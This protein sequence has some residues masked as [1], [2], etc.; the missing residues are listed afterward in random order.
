MKK[1]SRIQKAAL[2]SAALCLCST[3]AW[4]GNSARND[5]SV[6]SLNYA[7]ES[8]RTLIEIGVQSDPTFS[9]YSLKNPDRVVVEILDCGT[10]ARISPVQV[11]NGVIDTA[12]ISVSQ[13]NDY[14]TCRV[15]LGLEQETT[16]SVD[17]NDKMI[18]VAVNGKPAQSNA[19]LVAA[20]ESMKQ[21]REDALAQA[22]AIAA[23]EQAETV[24]E[25][26]RANAALAK[27]EADYAAAQQKLAIAES[28]R[29]AALNDAKR[30]DSSNTAEITRIQNELSLAQN[31]AK[32]LEAAR[33][34]AIA[35]AQAAESK[36]SENQ[37]IAAQD[38]ATSQAE[39]K[40]ERDRANAALAKLEASYAEA[41][42]KLAIAE[43]QRDAALNDAQRKD[44]SNSAEIT[45]IQNELIL[46][47][48]NA[49]ALEAARNQAIVRAQAA[50]SQLSANQASAAR[51]L[52][53]SQA[54]LKAERDR[55][56]AALAKLEAS[57]AEAQQKLA[58][59][60]S[61]RDNALNDAQ[62]KNSSNSAE[63]ARMQDELGKAQ[64][65]VKALEAARNQ[66][67]IRA[68]D[69]ELQLS[70]NQASAARI[71]N[72]LTLAQNNAK[73]LEAARNQ[74]ITRAQDAESALAS[75]QNLVAQN[76]ARIAALEAD[77]ANARNRA[78]TLEQNYSELASENADL[79]KKLAAQET[80][81]ARLNKEVV[82]GGAAREKLKKLDAKNA[83][84]EA[85]IAELKAQAR[86]G[87]HALAE[88]DKLKAE[89]AQLQARA[90]ALRA[91]NTVIAAAPETQSANTVIASTVPPI[92]NSVATTTVAKSTVT[93]PVDHQA[94]ASASI[95]DI[96]FRN[97]PDNNGMQ[98]VVKL[99]A[100]VEKVETQDIGA[101][102]SVLKIANAVLPENFNKKFDT[103]AFNQ[104]VRFV[105]S[106]QGKGGI[107]LIA[108]SSSR[109]VDAVEQNGDT[110][111][112]NIKPLRD[113]DF[114]ATVDRRQQAM[115]TAAEPTASPSS[116]AY[117]A[118]ALKNTPLAKR[119]ITIDIHDADINDLLRLLSDEINT[120]IVVSPDVKG[121]VTLSLKSVPLDQAMNIILRMQDLGMRYEGNVIW[122]A[123]AQQFRE[124]EERALKAAE[125]R[126]KLE[127]LEVRLI[128][129]NYATASELSGN[130][131]AMMS[132]RG[133]VNIDNRTNTLILK[134]V[135]A[136]LDAAE[137]LVN[138]LDTQTPQVLIEARIVETQANFTKEIGI[139]WGGDGI[140]SAATGNATGIVFPSTIG[141]A[142]GSTSENNSGTSATPNFAVNLPAAVGTGRGGAIGL[143]LGSV[144]GAINLNIRLSALESKG[145]LKI[146]SAPRIMTL[147]NTEASIE[148]GT[149]IP[150]SVVSAAGAQTVF[151]DA[152][153]N[154]QVTPHVTRDGNIYLKIG[155]SKDEPDFGNTGATGD[156]S[157]I[158][159][160]AHTELLIPDGET[161]VIG[162]IYTRNTGQSMAS[163][164][165]FGSIPI[166]GYL[167]RNTS[168]TDNRTELLIFITPRI[169]NRDA[170]IAASGHGSFIPPVEREDSKN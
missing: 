20:Y 65:E 58:I 152:K 86:Q 129:V 156:P 109:T 57:Y 94:A 107:E 11:R 41:Q 123:P 110:I 80:E 160:Q 143:T 130:I 164:P 64:N 131:Q 17:S 134:D 100:P 78:N 66:A 55:A 45:R 32:A 67:I 115:L 88:L 168:E 28:Q 118:D 50:E 140:A 13:A 144:G 97:N 95:K 68:Q 56:N 71:Q 48:N 19:D 27:L 54:E 74:A 21:S 154:L 128:P 158:K 149:S 148:Q 142:G 39:L 138:N 46:A 137:I 104:G 83:Q 151:Y 4:D 85:Q 117:G 92:D 155:I 43:S 101:Q 52:A 90:E 72:E 153:L 44:S 53:N 124:E 69:A 14:S 5:N 82:A 108:Q 35:R 102:K 106:T 1:T 6:T 113:L 62:R 9:V 29:D 73:A 3:V 10:N 125:V 42:Q 122:V 26:D 99:S 136:N 60:E 141:I 2:L 150:I 23:K 8:S 59:A 127:P 135:A 161:T 165:F 24:A 105:D 76:N 70:A 91:Q 25:R 139:Q 96:Q 84:D 47:Q 40:A 167:F 49:K 159:K 163:V 114:K 133:T 22:R 157:I 116:M 63:I 15:I 12:A 169:I 61:Q 93:A 162:G 30:K 146:V 77:N 36:L 145:F 34:Q 111:I 112:W 81:M 51:N 170:S 75:S 33:N 79:L 119:K 31:N 132:S 38:R 126:E 18:T 89:N 166:L 147:D 16:Y 37:A 103:S 7:Q 120:S 87:R 98:V 121:N